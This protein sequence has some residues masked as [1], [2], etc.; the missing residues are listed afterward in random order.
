[1]P[2]AVNEDAL[3]T[4]LGPVRAEMLRLLAEPVTMGSLARVLGTGP[5]SATYH[6]GQLVAAGLVARR[7][8]GKAVSVQRTQLGEA[9]IG[10][11]ER[12]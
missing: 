5:S 9:L 6:C 7:R 2:T 1:M 10:L 3:T 11:F 4:L 8:T 12:P